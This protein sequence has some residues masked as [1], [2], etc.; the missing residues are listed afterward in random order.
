MLI[1]LGSKMIWQEL[2]PPGLTELAM[3]NVP[4]VRYKRL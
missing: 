4:R 2:F 3:R 1:N